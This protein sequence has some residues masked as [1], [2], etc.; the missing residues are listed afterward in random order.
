MVQKIS[1][2]Q[3]K[4]GYK[5]LNGSKDIFWTKLCYGG[6]GGGGEGEGIK[7]KADSV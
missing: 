5:R 1:S 4:F 6:G 3:T 2:G 7:I